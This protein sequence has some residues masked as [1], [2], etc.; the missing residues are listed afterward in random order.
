MY[1]DAIFHSFKKCHWT[2]LYPIEL[3]GY[4]SSLS[5]EARCIKMFVWHSC[6]SIIG[7]K[8]VRSIVCCVNFDEDLVLHSKQD[9]S[10]MNHL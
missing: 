7:L 2:S 6:M 1:F 8:I 3:E 4:R 5:Y 9:S 10:G